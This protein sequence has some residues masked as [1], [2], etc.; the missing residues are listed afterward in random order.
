M[1]IHTKSIIL[2]VLIFRQVMSCLH[3]RCEVW[4]F[5]FKLPCFFAAGGYVCMTTRGD[6]ENLEYKVE[7]ERVIRAMEQE[8][9]WSHV[10]VTVVDKWEKAVSENECGY[11]PGAVYICQRAY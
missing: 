10:A 6:A 9:K 11:I 8:K 1:S 7:L 2:H 3:I 4:A 5:L